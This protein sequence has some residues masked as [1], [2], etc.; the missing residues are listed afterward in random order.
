[1]KPND[2]KSEN[3]II[4]FSEDEIRGFAKELNRILEDSERLVN[5]LA[6]AILE[7]NKDGN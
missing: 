2:E 6:D 7:A 3:K 4:G 5:T 1:M